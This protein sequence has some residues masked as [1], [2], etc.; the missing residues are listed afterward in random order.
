MSTTEDNL[1]T[2][3][4]IVENECLFNI[5]L[6]QRLFE[7]EK[8]EVE[9]LLQ[10]LWYAYRKSKDAPY[11]I[12]MLTAVEKN[13]KFDLV[14]G[15]QRFTSLILLAIVLCKYNPIWN[16]FL[17]TDRLSLSARSKDSEYLT[18]LISNGIQ[19]GDERKNIKMDIAMKIMMGYLDDN[20]RE[21][22]QRISFASFVY[23]NLTF[24][25]S[26]LP[27]KYELQDLNR[28]FETMNSTGRNLESYEI[29][30]V[31]LLN[32]I[33]GDRQQIFTKIWNAV[34]DMNKNLIREK[35]EENAELRR[36]RWEAALQ[37]INP[38][39]I[40]AFCNDCEERETKEEC[41]PWATIESIKPSLQPPKDRRKYKA[42]SEEDGDATYSI[43][44]FS[45][46][47]LQVLYLS[48][49][50]EER[51]NADVTNFFDVHQLQETFNSYIFNV[52]KVYS[53]EYIGNLLK[54]RL[55][56]DYYI[57]RITY[58][59]NG[60]SNYNLLFNSEEE[61]KKSLCMYESMLYVN[62]GST[63]YYLWLPD[64]LEYLSKI[65]HNAIKVKEVLDKLKQIDDSTHK[66]PQNYE[67]LCYP[68]IERYWFWRLDYYLWEQRERWF[69]SEY[70]AIDVVKDFVF[71][72]NRS[73][74][75]L[76]SQKEEENKKWSD[77][78]NIHS[79]G[80]LAMISASFNS[81]QNNNPDSVKFARIREQANNHSLQSIKMY[82]MF[83]K[84]KGHSGNWTESLSQEHGK[85]MFELLE[86]TYTQHSDG[87][88]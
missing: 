85:E 8:E 41:M 21:T 52:A 43:L 71:R 81:Q 65:K 25:I 14:D 1:Y 61:T 88:M 49:N 16:T 15:Q 86:A 50:D 39:E 70:D 30:K 9:Q 56:F 38:V 3:Q 17:S 28:Y 64:L 32:D 37:I 10:D 80:N 46:F 53:E 54:Y 13:E 20:I 79:F 26:L 84:A 7:W 45:E 48:L 44:S 55:L 31:K 36:S 27:S 68:N 82:L 19:I 12:G 33:N 87:Q 29:I 4:K 22:E 69:G 73:I 63:T 57:L 62:S 83:L 34:E 24:F 18:H 76:H 72:R 42:N 40:W 77:N 66:H 2:P 6:Y 5:P 75:H 23:N 35:R 78:K 11:Y 58:D 47:M 74:E 51:K 67:I 59:E 60:S